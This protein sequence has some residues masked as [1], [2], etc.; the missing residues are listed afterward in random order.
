MSVKRS[1][2]NLNSKKCQTATRF[3][4]REKWKRKPSY[5]K[6]KLTVKKRNFVN[7]EETNKLEK[8]IEKIEKSKDDS[9]RM[10]EAIKDLNKMNQKTQLL[11]KEG[12]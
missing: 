4:K 1:V 5:K 12:N 8:Q 3:I 6:K 9:S 7:S 10:F 2:S 11:I